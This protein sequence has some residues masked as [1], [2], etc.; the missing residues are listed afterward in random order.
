MLSYFK[1]YIGGKSSGDF[2]H[3]NIQLDKGRQNS[4]VSGYDQHVYRNRQKKIVQ[5]NYSLDKIRSPMRPKRS[6]NNLEKPSYTEAKPTA[7]R[8]KVDDDYL[9]K[10]RIQ[11]ELNPESHF[12]KRNYWNISLQ[13]DFNDDEYFKKQQKAKEVVRKA[14]AKERR[15]L[16]HFSER[17]KIEQNNEVDR[18]LLRSLKAKIELL[19]HL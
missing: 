2:S 17:E 16:E 8:K 15:V 5:S 18:M 9:L 4:E 7:K 1:N 3:R 10:K 12:K 6:R 11:R 19:N 14:L 13:S